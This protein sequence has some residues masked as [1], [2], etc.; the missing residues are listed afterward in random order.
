M[1]LGHLNI[2]YYALT[3]LGGVA[4]LAV[5]ATIERATPDRTLRYFLYYHGSFTLLAALNLVSTYLKTNVDPEGGMVYAVVRYL[6]NPVAL[7]M[8]MFTASAFIHALVPVRHPALRNRI[9]GGLVLLLLLVNY[10]L[11]LFGPSPVWNDARILLKDI[12][13]VGT[14]F[15]CWITLLLY[16]RNVK[17][18]VE[19]RFIGTVTFFFAV[20]IPGIISD[21]FLL[22][23]LGFKVFP[24]IY[25]V[26]GVIFVRYFTKNIQSD[27]TEIAADTVLADTGRSSGD[28]LRERGL[29]QR[30]IDVVKLL[31]LGDSYGTVGESLFISQNTVKTHL[32][33]A[34]QKLGV[35]N[36]IELAHLIRD[37]SSPPGS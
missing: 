10:T 26:M 17:D 20:F 12:A 24:L 37:L 15:Y 2:L 30:E 9:A 18:E 34:Y 3:L 5:G 19:R 27:A 1:A 21:T 29:T 36:R 31:A 7:L 32:R 4:V 13:F 14:I 25:C 8:V 11:S 22:A 28:L 23:H 35:R 33:K 16:L 6:E